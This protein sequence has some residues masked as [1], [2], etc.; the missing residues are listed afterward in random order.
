MVTLDGAKAL[1]L[2]H[3]IGSI[4]PGKYA[5]LTAV[6]LADVIEMSPC[7]DPVSHLVYAAGREHVSHVWVQGKEVVTDGRLTTLNQQQ[8]VAK[9]RSW[10]RKIAASE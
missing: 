1:G 3:D 7:Y 4:Q 10:Q 6:N 9:T 8:I 2:D 5:D